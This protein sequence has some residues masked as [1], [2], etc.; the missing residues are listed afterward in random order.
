M[1]ASW[2]AGVYTWS[3][4]CDDEVLVYSCPPFLKGRIPLAAIEAVGISDDRHMDAISGADALRGLTGIKDGL[5]GLMIAWRA[6]RK[7]RPTLSTIAFDFG[8]EAG[9][10]FVVG[11]VGRLPDRFLGIGTRADLAKRMGVRRALE[12]VIAAGVI[13]A[14]V[15]ICGLIE[16]C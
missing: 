12:T 3:V 11:F 10:G 14:I 15:V 6:P 13:A 1:E 8:D 4:R 7:A 9:R 2:K 16:F 5:G